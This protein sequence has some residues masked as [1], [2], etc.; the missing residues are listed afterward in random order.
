MNQAHVVISRVFNAPRNLVWKAWTEAE[1]LAKWWG[2]KGF[3]VSVAS[4][5]FRP[6]G[7][8]HYSMNGPG[9]QPMWGKFV[10]REIVALEKIV[11]INS[12]SDPQ[13]GYTRNP[14]IPKWPLEVLNNQ[15]FTEQAGQTTVT[16]EGGPIN[17]TPEEEQL[18]AD[19]RQNMTIGFKGTFEQLDELLAALK[20]GRS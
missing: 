17:C 18:F 14:W 2:P 10:Y 15:T 4:F 6:G 16:L 19:N 9:G 20:D 12:F 5:D 13:G 7:M 1:H 3:T 8:F 11:F